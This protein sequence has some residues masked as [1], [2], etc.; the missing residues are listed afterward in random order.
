MFDQQFEKALQ[1]KIELLFSDDVFSDYEPTLLQQEAITSLFKCSDFCIDLCLKFPGEAKLLL[2]NAGHVEN[3]T[4]E[5]YR[6]LLQND[7]LEIESFD[8]LS[9]VL[10]QFRYQK[11]LRI[12][13]RDLVDNISV[14]QTLSEITWLADACLEIAIEKLT[15][16]AVKKYGQPLKDDGKPMQLVV[17][18]MGKMG[19]DELNFSSD[20]DL[21]FCYQNEGEIQREKKPLAHSEFFIR[22]CQQLVRLLSDVTAYGF[23]YRVDIRLRPFGDSGQLALSFDAME[24]YYERHGREWERYA[25]VKARPVSLDLSAAKEISEILQPFVYRRYFDFSAFSSLREMKRLIDGEVGLKGAEKNVKLGP[26]GIREIEFIGQA[27]QLIRGGRSPLLQERSI[28]FILTTLHEMDLIPEFVFSSLHDAYLFLRKT[29]NA[30]Q[31]FAEQQTHVLPEDELQQLRLAYALGFDTWAGFH[32]MLLQHMSSVHEHFEQIFSAPQL[33]V[34]SEGDAASDEFSDI[35]FDV[36]ESPAAQLV[37]EKSGYVE[38]DKALEKIHGLAQSSKYKTMGPNGKLRFDKLMPMLIPMIGKVDN[39]D[40]CLL[41]VVRLLEAIAKR[42]AYIALLAENPMGL[43]QLVQLFDKSQWIA[44][45]LIRQPILLDELIDPRRLYEPMLKQD[46]EKELDYVFDAHS[47]DVELQVQRIIDFKQSNFLRVAA[48]QLMGFMSVEKVSDHLTYIAEVSAEA[49]SALAK[50][51]QLR[52]YGAPSYLDNEKKQEAGFCVIAYGKLGGLELGFG[53]DLDLVFL[54]DSHGEQQIT[55][56]KKAVDNVVFFAKLGQRIILFLNTPTQ[57]GKLYEVD[58]R[59]R[60]SGG[61]GVLVSSVKSFLD[62]QENKAWTWEHQALIRARCV[63]GSDSLKEQFSEIRKNILCQQRDE[64]TLLKDVADMRK[65]MRSELLK[66][67]KGEFD[68]K[69][70]P[71]GITDIEFII[72]FLILRWAHEH[73]DVIEYTDNLRLIDALLINALISKDD[74]KM[75]RDAYLAYRHVVHQCAL[76]DKS[77]SHFGEGDFHDYREGVVGIWKKIFDE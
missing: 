13:W 29:E 60:P 30:I 9:V 26:G 25:M 77:T 76:Q 4:K 1:E 70:S 22:L 38:P 18:A 37:L 32:E 23:V 35:W 27:F 16:W 11:T 36:I 28:L 3:T 69:Q 49:V 59:L 7:V 10:R 19:A 5:T 71:G 8:E 63:S 20:I 66:N 62:Y 34:M 55:D 50:N 52:R 44:D 46:L 42:T 14:E 64:K 33:D 31:A 6:Q 43:S 61:S 56:G 57:S 54:H 72:Q 68:L 17:L 45:L 74:A 41:R 65:R 12:A 48:S 73:P 67:R 15:Y 47:D 24:T 40:V 58:M 2:D 39:S 51:E 75:L 53:S 21:I